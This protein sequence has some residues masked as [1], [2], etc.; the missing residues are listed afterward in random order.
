MYLDKENLFSED[1]AITVTAASTDVI[2][3]GLT[4]MGRGEEIE[5]LVQVTTDFADG[6]SL[7]VALQTD[8]NAG[9]SSAATLFS[10]AAIATAS[11]VAGYTF[12]MGK[13]P[14]NL[15]E[16]YVRLYYTVVGTM[17]A[18]KVVAGLIKDRQ[19]WAALPDAL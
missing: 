13:L 14:D 5:I 16:R 19:N 18:G 10:S 15:V 11:L 3:L 9:F 12:A 17:S 8:D 6:T 1:Q 7:Q 4:E 2:D